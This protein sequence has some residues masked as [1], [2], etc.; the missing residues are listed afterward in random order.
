MPNHPNIDQDVLVKITDYGI[1]TISSVS[2]ELK[3]D[4]ITGTPGFIAPEVYD[5]F[6]GQ[7]V[8]QSDKVRTF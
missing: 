7:Q 8:L 2:Q 1:S 4:S 5:A 6:Q 3:C